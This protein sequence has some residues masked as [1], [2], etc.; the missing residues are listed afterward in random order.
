MTNNLAFKIGS[1]ITFGQRGAFRVEDH[2]ELESH[3]GKPGNFYYSLTPILLETYDAEGNNIAIGSR[4]VRGD[5]IESK[6]V[7]LAQSVW[8]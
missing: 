3:E 6:A 1:I 4:I 7:L 8:I 2:I 5:Y